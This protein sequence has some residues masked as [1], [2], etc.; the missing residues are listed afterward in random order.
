[1]P[2]QEKT[3]MQGRQKLAY[4]VLYEG[5]SVSQAA[6][7]AG[8]SRV[9]AHEWVGRAQRE[10]IAQMQ[11]YSRRPHHS[12]RVTRQTQKAREQALALK[13]KR[14]AW[15]AKKLNAFLWPPDRG[16]ALVCVR[17]VDR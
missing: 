17:S 11:E 14:P 15:G 8:V 6:R 12:P 9:T 1:M 16:Q 10:G 7:E 4:Q 5:V 3:R 2:F 13:A